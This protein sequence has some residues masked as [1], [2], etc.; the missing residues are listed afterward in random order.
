MPIEVHP[1]QRHFGATM[2]GID[3][4]RPQTADE[5]AAIEAGMDKHA[6]LVLPGQDI[7]DLL[8]V[9]FALQRDEIA[10]RAITTVTYPSAR[11]ARL[12]KRLLDVGHRPGRI[13]TLPTDDLQVL[14]DSVG[15]FR[16][17]LVVP[18]EDAAQA[19]RRDIRLHLRGDDDKHSADMET[20]FISQGAM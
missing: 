4:R 10:V 11:R 19:A 2:T 9:L 3:V 1:F 17:M 6:V 15:T 16:I 18:S 20:V 8:A 7:D 5:V 14:A 13:V 12:I